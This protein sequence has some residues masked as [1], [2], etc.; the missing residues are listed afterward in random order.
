MKWTS[1]IQVL[2][3]IF[4]CSGLV[5]CDFWDDLA[6]AVGDVVDEN[7]GGDRDFDTGLDVL[8]D[9]LDG[10]KEV[11]DTAEGILPGGNIGGDENSVFDVF[12]PVETGAS[13]EEGD[14]LEALLQ[15]LQDIAGQIGELVL[16]DGDLSQDDILEALSALIL[17]GEN[18]PVNPDEVSEFLLTAMLDFVL[19]DLGINV[20][21]E[22]VEDRLVP[23]IMDV[24][25]V[26]REY[27]SNSTS[28]G[29]S[30]EL[31]L[32]Q[33]VLDAVL[34]N[35]FPNMTREDIFCRAASNVVERFVEE[36]P[37]LERDAQK[38]MVRNLALLALGCQTGELRQ[39]FSD[40]GGQL[41]DMIIASLN[42]T[43]IQQILEATKSGIPETLLNDTFPSM[44]GG[45]FANFTRLNNPLLPPWLQNNLRPSLPSRLNNLTRNI[46]DMSRL[47]DLW[48]PFEDFDGVRTLLESFM[49][50]RGGAEDPATIGLPE[51]ATDEEEITTTSRTTFRTLQTAKESETTIFPTASPTWP[52][53]T[54]TTTSTPTKLQS[55]ASPT[56]T[57][58][59]STAATTTK[60]ATNATTSLPTV[61]TP[62]T[63]TAAN[64]TRTPFP[65]L[66]RR[67]RLRE[68]RG[69]LRDAVTNATE[70]L[71][72]LVRDEIR[73]S[74]L[75]QLISTLLE[76]DLVRQVLQALDIQL[77]PVQTTVMTMTST[78][79]VTTTVA[80]RSTL[81]FSTNDADITRV[82]SETEPVARAMT[83]TTIQVLQTAN[84][85]DPASIVSTLTQILVDNARQTIQD[86]VLS[87]PLEFVRGVV[88]FVSRNNSLLSRIIPQETIAAVTAGIG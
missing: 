36:V 57:L 77:N 41:K 25:K 40:Q 34:D 33:D 84:L 2:L 65:G 18:S 73:S 86:E 50:R 15:Q 62:A 30:V 79:T 38:T 45:R 17:D 68:L 82:S 49:D 10:A 4:A 39:T 63:A 55:T 51:Q 47:R 69:N 7:I 54:T 1:K 80:N 16:S 81:P 42:G 24:Y 9:I 28:S 13:N 70:R 44:L 58:V 88:D 56:T 27:A 32:I 46:A 48:Q 72:Q 74:D 76:S 53:V 71:V 78:E 87:D 60:N 23:L 21:D 52:T 11:L 8:D 66:M 83:Q 29:D 85:T 26:V 12:T 67:E 20:S 14:S 22:M 59:T 75:A 61:P 31:D 5:T 43:L 64:S 35:V 3:L 19:E 6:D 37:N